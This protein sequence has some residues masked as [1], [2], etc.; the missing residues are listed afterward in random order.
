MT[1]QRTDLPNGSCRGIALVVTILLLALATLLVLAILSLSRSEV[2]S[3][4]TYTRNLE[5][6][7]LADTAIS[8]SIGQIRSAVGRTGEAWTSQPGA[9]RKFDS[10]GNFLA[11]YKL[12]S[13]DDMIVDTELALV[14]DGP[15][16]IWDTLPDVWVDMN[17]PA[18][19]DSD[20]HFPILDPRAFGIV[21]GFSINSSSTVAGIVSATDVSARLPMPVQWLYVLQDGTVGHLDTAVAGNPFTAMDAAGAAVVPDASNPIVGRIAFW[22][23]DE[24]CKVNVNTASE[25]TPWSVPY[26]SATEDWDYADRQPAQNEWQRY[27]GHPAT[28]ALGSVLFGNRYQ[29]TGTGPKPYLQDGLLPYSLRDA[30]YSITP[31]IQRGGSDSGREPSQPGDLSLI[32]DVSQERDRLYSSLDEVLFAAQSSGGGV[33]DFAK[34]D[35]GIPIPG[36]QDSL[37]RS[38]FFLT[39]HSRAPELNLWNLPRMAIWPVDA[40]ERPNRYET[41]F[42]SLIA[43]CANTKSPSGS[44]EYLFRRNNEDRVDVDLPSPSSVSTGNLSGSTGR[45]A[46]LYRYIQ[47]LMGSATPGYGSTLAAKFGIDTNQVIT[48]VFDYIRST[49][50]HDDNH[51]PDEDNFIQNQTVADLG[52]QTQFTNARSDNALGIHRGHGQVAPLR[53]RVGGQETKGFGRFYSVSEAALHFICSADGHSNGATGGQFGGGK[54]GTIASGNINSSDESPV[55]HAG[56]NWWSNFPPLTDK[57]PTTNGGTS[58]PPN[59]NQGN[60]RIYDPVNGIAGTDPNHPGYDPENWNWAL[61]KDTPL[62]KDEKMVQM[63]FFLEWFSPSQGWTPIAG[64]FIVEVDGLD[65]FRLDT[66]DLCLPETDTVYNSR[67]LGESWNER[68]WG[69]SSGYRGFLADRWCDLDSDGRRDPRGSALL[70]DYETTNTSWWARER[71]YPFVSVPV[72]VTDDGKMNFVGGDVTIRLY[73]RTQDPA[74]FDTTGAGDASKYLI[75]T[76]E[77]EFG[78]GDFPIPELV[79]HGTRESF[80]SSGRI[81]AQGTDPH[82]WWTFNKHGS[83]RGENGAQGATARAD[84]SRWG[85]G[86]RRGKTDSYDWKS[87]GRISEVGGQP[88]QPY[89]RDFDGERPQFRGG[90]FLRREDVI[91]TLVPKH[92]DFRLIAGESMVDESVFV[93]HPSYSEAP[94]YNSSDPTGRMQHNLIV[95]GGSTDSFGFSN[96]VPSD[97]L[98]NVA[99][100]ATDNNYPNNQAPS[101]FLPDFPETADP[102]IVRRSRDFDNGISVTFDGPYINKPD[103]GNSR[104]AINGDVPYFQQNW[105][106]STATATYF[107]PNRQIPSPGMFGSLPTGLKQ[108]LPWQTLLFRRDSSHPSYRPPLSQAPDYLLMDLFWMPV[109]EP[110]AISEPFSTAGKINLNYDILPFRNYIKRSTGIHAVMKGERMLCIPDTYQRSGGVSRSSGPDYKRMDGTSPFVGEMRKPI[111][112]NETLKQFDAMFN[113][114]AVFRSAA[115]ICDVH[116]VPDGVTLPS[117]MTTLSQGDAAMD[118]FWDTHRLTG[119]NSRERP[120]T[121]I[122]GRLTTKSNTYRIHVIAQS[123]KKKPTGAQNT[124]DSAAGDNVLSEYRG[125]SLLERFLDPEEVGI[126]DYAAN[127]TTIGTQSLD[128]FYRFRVINQKRFA[129]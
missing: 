128:R 42:D 18:L 120:Y 26:A 41:G 5:A 58:L 49:N 2:R 66:N 39:A 51:N 112:V 14:G 75:Q 9:L 67:R 81:N 116:L 129:P 87:S 85:K 95:S 73:S 37:V 119:E 25:P 71:R 78:N 34:D 70:D 107:S 40:E 127:P 8:L 28:T 17:E 27:P 15:N 16:A 45:N 118:S 21:E 33:R 55:D 109:V 11:G 46:Q 56:D 24:T 106:Q 93:P 4:Y 110:Y 36:L 111:D 19:R 57:D 68:N 83:M 126:P 97:Q 117:N 32:I 105:S 48:Q 79:V 88:L 29:P 108:G 23:D 3:A 86:F 104:N 74:N 30:I 38:R 76:I 91:R 7:N 124:F 94:A 62:K 43:F 101:N 84:D 113:A 31:R 65:T 52:P 100:T 125:S 72:K 114:G 59:P 115:Q 92:G 35:V 47:T 96:K 53:V 103:E 61:P 22:G 54:G 69:G 98:T 77:L 13:D 44:Y 122:Y 60:A 121:N 10:S 99:Y 90:S 63:M 82:F 80:N 20:A 1:N 102:T 6:R 50:L 12:Y 123:L 89:R 64:D